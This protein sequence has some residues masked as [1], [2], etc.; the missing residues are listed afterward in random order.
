MA[1]VLLSE[2]DDCSLSL[3]IAGYEIPD[4]PGNKYDA[5]WIL[6]RVSVQSRYGNWS[7]TEPALLTWE[8]EDLIE[9]C[10]GRYEL[11]PLLQ[12]VEQSIEF[13]ATPVDSELTHLKVT[14]AGKFLPEWQDNSTISLDLFLRRDELRRFS[15]EL[16]SEL[17]KFPYRQTGID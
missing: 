2:L 6:I 3:E 13:Y 9:W 16:E 7:K 8:I 4:H 10:R 1:H 14:L 17:S 12:F 5:N 11:E 15:S